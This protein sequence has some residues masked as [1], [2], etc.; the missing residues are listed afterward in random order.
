MPSALCDLMQANCILE[1][2]LVG[3]D[4]RDQSSHEAGVRDELTPCDKYMVPS[5]E[6][7]HATDDET[8]AD[9]GTMRMQ[10][11]GTLH[12][13]ARN[14]TPFFDEQKFENIGHLRTRFLGGLQ[15]EQYLRR[16]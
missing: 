14:G 13:V 4:G 10:D 9:L 6:M 11:F 3:I 5:W 7:I 16:G 1:F 12:F 8:V 2:V 15:I